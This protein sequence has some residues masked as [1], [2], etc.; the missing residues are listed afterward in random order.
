MTAKYISRRGIEE[1]ICVIRGQKVIMDSDI[2]WLYGVKTKVLLQAVKRNRK[3]FP[4]D[5]ILRLTQEEY[6]SLRSQIVTSKQGGRRY[7]PYMFTEQG[8]AMLSGVLTSERAILVNIAIMRAFV[9]VREMIERNTELAQKL[10][11]LERKIGKHDQEI[12]VIFQT[13]K[14]LMKPPQPPEEK[15]KKGIGFHVKYD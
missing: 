3:R 7:L 2:A 15:P 14:E 9:K 12:F 13:I 1:R 5:F 8:V 6:L 4:G 10:T 11:E